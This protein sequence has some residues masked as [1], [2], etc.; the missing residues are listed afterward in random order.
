MVEGRE[1]MEKWTPSFKAIVRVLILEAEDF[2]DNH[3]ESTP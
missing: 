1:G 2:I 3:Q